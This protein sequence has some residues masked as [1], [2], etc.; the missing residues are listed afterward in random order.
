MVTTLHYRLQTV[1]TITCWGTAAA[2]LFPWQ[3]QLEPFKLQPLQLCK[4]GPG[5]LQ[6]MFTPSAIGQLQAFDLSCMLLKP[7]VKR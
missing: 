6:A 7:A 5:Q 3:Q 4:L 1:R 2:V